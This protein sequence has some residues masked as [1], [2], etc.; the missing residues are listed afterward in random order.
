MIDF[1]LPAL[2]RHIRTLP[3][4][5]ETFHLSAYERPLPQ[6]LQQQIFEVCPVTSDWNLWAADMS[7]SLLLELEAHTPCLTTLELHWRRKGSIVGY[8]K[9]PDDII[10]AS[11]LLFTYL[12]NSSYAV[13]L[14][15]LKAGVFHHDMDIYRRGRYSNHN[16]LAVDSLPPSLKETLTYS[17]I[18]RCRN[19]RV[20]HINLRDP[21]GSMKRR[22]QSRIVY[23]YISKVVPHLEVL[24]IFYPYYNTAEGAFISGLQPFHR[25]P[26]VLD[27]G[28]CLLGRL[29]QLRRLSVV[30]AGGKSATSCKEMD[31]NWMVPS[32]RSG[33]KFRVMR[34]LEVESWQHQQFIEEQ[35]YQEQDQE[36][37]RQ[38]DSISGK[39]GGSLDLE[40]RGQLRN[41]G[42]LSEV[43]EMISK[44]DTGSIVPF[45]SLRGLS[46]EHPM[47]RAPEKELKELFS[48]RT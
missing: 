25:I 11:R 26:M 14:T 8:E 47:L 7:P 40:L 30:S 12:C 15:T 19:L 36:Q 6:E 46:F 24:E 34:R 1:D 17:G 21:T 5:L 38:D 10:S 20:L 13:H 37:Q 28:F 41:L 45:P 3:L 39:D 48:D 9:S 44:I 22:L 33:D 27:G 42:L 23:G 32:G 4:D 29:R 43:A 2:L 35:W 18:W 16:K 31:L